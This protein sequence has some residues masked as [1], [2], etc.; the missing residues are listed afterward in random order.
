[1]E[2]SVL[3]TARPDVDGADRL[4]LVRR[5]KAQAELRC[6]CDHPE[7][8]HYRQT[9][10]PSIRAWDTKPDKAHQEGVPTPG[11]DTQNVF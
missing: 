9:R 11:T 5:T 2:G 4:V 7:K 3:A 6:G 8:H 10:T 1:L